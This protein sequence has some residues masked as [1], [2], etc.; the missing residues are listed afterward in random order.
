MKQQF[1]WIT[2]NKQFKQIERRNLQRYR[3]NNIESVIK[4]CLI[5]N[6]SINKQNQR[7]GP[8]RFAAEFNKT[9]KEELMTIFLKLFH[10][11]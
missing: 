1:K 8:N 11:I 7:P 9:F 10:K 5:I 6:P 2:E 3:S 4:Y